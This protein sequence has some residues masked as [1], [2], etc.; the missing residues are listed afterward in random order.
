[1]YIV[2]RLV[3]VGGSHC[4]LYRWTRDEQR[5]DALVNFSIFKPIIVCFKKGQEVN[6]RHDLEKML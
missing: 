4:G 3:V 1:M 6:N 2:S 5:T